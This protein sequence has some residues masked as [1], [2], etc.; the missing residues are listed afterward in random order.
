MQSAVIS[1]GG[2]ASVPSS[3]QKRSAPSRTDPT[4]RITPMASD[5]SPNAMLSKAVGPES[6]QVTVITPP[7]KVR[8]EPSATNDAAHALR[9]M[10]PPRARR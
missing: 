8:I 3:R 1:A 7:R 9:W 5:G 4:I 2:S 10:L 6:G